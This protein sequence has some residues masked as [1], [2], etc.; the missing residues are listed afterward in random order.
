MSTL[1]TINFI[2]IGA[3]SLTALVIMGY[4]NHATGGRIIP[5]R[6]EPWR[7]LGGWRYHPSGRSLMGLLAIVMFIT[8]N[9]AFQ[10]LLAL[11]LMVKAVFYFGLYLVFIYSLARIGFTIRDEV[12][13]GRRHQSN[14]PETG[15]INIIAKLAKDPSHEH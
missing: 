9:A 4:W 2:L 11:P 8:F 14:L 10:G 6:G 3:V 7:P 15:D 1:Y 12:R 5:R 13:R